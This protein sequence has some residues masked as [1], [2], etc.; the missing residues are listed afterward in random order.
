MRD[1]TDDGDDQFPE[2]PLVSADRQQVQQSLRRVRTIRLARIQHAD[3]LVDVLGHHRLSTSHRIPDDKHVHL[4]RLQRVN[5]IEK[6]FAFD[7]R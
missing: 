4:H 7:L 6:F 2:C 5:G 1:I 3:V